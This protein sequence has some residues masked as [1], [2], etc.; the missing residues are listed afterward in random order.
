MKMMIKEIGRLSIDQAVPNTW[1]IDETQTDEGWNEIFPNFFAN[2]AI[3][4][5]AGLSQQEKTIFFNGIAQQ[6]LVNPS[7]TGQVA[8]DKLFVIDLISSISLNNDTLLQISFKGNFAVQPNVGAIEANIPT[9]EQTI[10]L[11]YATYIVDIDTQATAIMLPA[12]VNQLGSLSAT[13]SDRLYCYRIVFAALPTT[14]TKINTSPV[15]YVI[16]AEPKEEK[17]YQYLMRLK[18]S[19]DLQQSFDVDGNRPH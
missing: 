18:K 10:Y 8:G 17:E 11:Q 3:L 1:T 12:S 14:A 15:R 5:L 7:T 9:F 19:Y 16:G 6:D 2:E 4:D 13:A